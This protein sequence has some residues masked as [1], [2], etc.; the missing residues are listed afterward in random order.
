MLLD[1]HRPCSLDQ[2]DAVSEQLMLA[3]RL[4][5]TSGSELNELAHARSRERDRLQDMIDA[6]CNDY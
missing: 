5:G 1:L 6:R 2:F 4:Q 3:A